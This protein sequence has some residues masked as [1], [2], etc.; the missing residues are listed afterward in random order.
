MRRTLRRSTLAPVALLLVAGC[1]TTGADSGPAPLPNGVETALR[2]GEAAAAGGDVAGAVRL[3]ETLAQDHPEV[4]EAR[5]ALANAYYLAGAWPE[6]EESYRAL[7]AL[8]AGSVDAVIGLGRVALTKGDAALAETHFTAA[9]ARDPESLAARN[10]LAVSLDLRGR[11]AEAQRQYDEILAREPANRAV[12]SNR[13][14]S[15]ALGGDP[16]AAIET[17]D[18]LARAP[19][20]VPQAA[21]NLALAYALSGQTDESAAVLAAEL[22]PQQARDNLQFYRSIRR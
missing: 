16:R 4:P 9:L 1:A 10:G 3:F 20:R 2:L 21:H 6:A 8:D 18:E 5:R 15:V 12:M 13:A 11:H 17:L 19:V 14:L 22:P 7:A